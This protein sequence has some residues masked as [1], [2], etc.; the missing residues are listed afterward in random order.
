MG[1]M[2]ER[3]LR[4]APQT[5]SMSPLSCPA[6]TAAGWG[7]RNAVPISCVVAV[8]TVASRARWDRRIFRMS[9]SSVPLIVIPAASAS[10]IQPPSSFNCRLSLFR[11]NSI[12]SPNE[13]IFSAA[14]GCTSPRTIESSRTAGWG[15]AISMHVS[16][17]EIVSPSSSQPVLRSF[18][19]VGDHVR[20]AD[21]CSASAYCF[22][23]RQASIMVRTAG[24][25]SVT[26]VQNVF[27]ISGESGP[28]ALIRCCEISSRIFK[29]LSRNP[30]SRSVSKASL[31][32]PSPGGPE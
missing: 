25:N 16:M 14:D 30:P 5:R 21:R 10:S 13:A 2:L 31:N 8:K 6:F 27:S 15:L 29:R 28:A 24:M 4:C 20:A 9:S 17:D 3:A 11:Y 22:A 12:D 7:K 1:C 19:A 26:L 32:F 18:N 23:R